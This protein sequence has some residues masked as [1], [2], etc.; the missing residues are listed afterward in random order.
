MNV[1]GAHP[2][3]HRRLKWLLA[4]LIC[5]GLAGVLFRK[6]IQDAILL[7][8]LL[9]A[10]SPSE[11][12]FQELADRAKDPFVFLQQFMGQRKNPAP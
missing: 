12:V 5:V 1:S 8:S 11:T 10:D 9:M 3:V 2:F 7:R 4:L 6:P